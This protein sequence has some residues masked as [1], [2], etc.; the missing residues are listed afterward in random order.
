MPVVFLFLAAVLIEIKHVYVG[1]DEVFVLFE[2]H[3]LG[4]KTVLHLLV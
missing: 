4:L 2:E 1:A 3:L